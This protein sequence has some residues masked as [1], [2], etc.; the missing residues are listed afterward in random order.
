MSMAKHMVRVAVLVGMVAGGVAQAYVLGDG[1]M[2]R[3]S[4]DRS[5]GDNRGPGSLNSGPGLSGIESA[6]PTLPMSCRS[7][8]RRR[9]RIRCSDSPISR[10]IMSQ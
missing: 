6:M 7:P 8:A 5:G 3:G 4:Q 10:A 1:E 2:L 9:R